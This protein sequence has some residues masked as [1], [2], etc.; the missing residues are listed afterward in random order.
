MARG[1]AADTGRFAF[2]EGVKTADCLK[3]IYVG[4]H[5][6]IVDTRAGQVNLFDLMN[7]PQERR[8]LP[9]SDVHDALLQN[10]QT[11]M[12]ATMAETREVGAGFSAET[13][14]LSDETRERLRSLGYVD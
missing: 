12:K 1:A 9:P 5:K 3:A 4:M 14:P 10:L 11:R 7:D 2:A 13:A 6:M 8:M